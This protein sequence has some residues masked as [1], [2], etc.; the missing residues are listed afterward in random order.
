MAYLNISKMSPIQITQILPYTNN[1]ASGCRFTL[2]L[3]TLEDLPSISIK[4]VTMFV[5]Y[6]SIMKLT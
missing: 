5:T 6:Y 4:S 1:N 2:G 3:K